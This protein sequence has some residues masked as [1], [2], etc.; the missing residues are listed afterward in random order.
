MGQTEKNLTDS[1]FNGALSFKYQSEKLSSILKQS[2]VSM[3]PYDS[4]ATPWFSQL[5]DQGKALVIEKIEANIA[6]YTELFEQG[7]SLRDSKKL[8]WQSLKS[9]R[10]TFRSD[11]FDFFNEGDVIEVY[12]KNNIQVFC[13]LDFYDYCSYTIEDIYCRPWV[14]LFIREDNDSLENLIPVL[15]GFYDGTIN[16]T[17]SMDHLGVHSVIEKDSAFKNHFNMQIKY[18]SPIFDEDTKQPYGF[19]AVEAAEITKTLEPQPI[20]DSTETQRDLD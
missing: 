17:V 20:L 19:V 2:D 9:S 18:L 5:T 14:E 1:G 6:V 15:N 8:M 12:D 10:L 7:H 13:N 16:D 3:R 11:L 4:A